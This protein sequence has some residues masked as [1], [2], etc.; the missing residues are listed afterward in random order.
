MLEM[1][2]YLVQI[3]VILPY[4]VI[5]THKWEFIPVM[6]VA[7]VFVTSLIVIMTAVTV[8]RINVFSALPYFYF[9]R[10]L[11][12]GLFVMSFVEIFILRKF[13]THVVGWGTEGRRVAL[14]AESLKDIAS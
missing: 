12:L 5:T 8:K 6:I 14:S 4:I 9:L 13:R 1:L 11:E 3:F 2:I 10:W 7:D